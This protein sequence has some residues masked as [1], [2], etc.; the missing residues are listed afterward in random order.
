M[1]LL[2]GPLL[3]QRLWLLSLSL[4]LSLSLLFQQQ[5]PC[6]QRFCAFVTA[7]SVSL[8]FTDCRAAAVEPTRRQ[9]QQRRVRRLSCAS[10]NHL[11]PKGDRR[12]T[13]CHPHRACPCLSDALR[14]AAV[15]LLLVVVMMVLLL[16]VVTMIM[17][18]LLC[19]G[20]GLWTPPVT[21]R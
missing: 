7:V 14:A 1:L 15:V 8:I 20:T 11:A 21:R 13:S 18:L 4:S 2:L 3:S 9:A 6:R 5:L 16:V 17:V 12:A 10:Y 19:S